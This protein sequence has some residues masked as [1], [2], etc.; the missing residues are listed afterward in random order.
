M[1]FPTLQ[2]NDGKLISLEMVPLQIRNMRLNRASREDTQWL[3]ST[4]DR[5]GKALD[6]GVRLGPDDVLQ[7]EWK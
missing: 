1:Y 5:E 4:L 6:T 3:A 7:L 2:S